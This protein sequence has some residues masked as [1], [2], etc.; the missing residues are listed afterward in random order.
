[1]SEF[2]GPQTFAAQLT[3]LGDLDAVGAILTGA[4]L[5]LHTDD[6]SPDKDTV[7][8]DLT[9]PTYTGY[10]TEAVTWN[11]PSEG[12]GETAE[13]VGT[14]GE[15]RPTD[16]LGGAQTVWGASLRTAAGALIAACRFTDGPYAMDDVN[17]AIL[18]TVRV[19]LD[20]TIVFNV[21]A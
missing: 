11:A 21:I 2:A 13:M 8:G 9:A 10:A 1:M 19:R 7:A 14:A 15:F 6:I 3:I 5:H 20:E 16:A 18:V 12:P 4:L 17:D